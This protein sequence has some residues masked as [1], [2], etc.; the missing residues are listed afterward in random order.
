[1]LQ[2][3]QQMGYTAMTEVQARCI[4]QL[5]AGRDLLGAAKT[6]QQRPLRP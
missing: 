5:M 3:V 1:M 6:G 2:A 4:P